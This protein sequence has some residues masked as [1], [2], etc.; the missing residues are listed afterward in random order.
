MLFKTNK[1]TPTPGM[2]VSSKTLLHYTCYLS[3]IRTWWWTDS[4][5]YILPKPTNENICCVL[6][7]VSFFRPLL[8]LSLYWECKRDELLIIMVMVNFIPEPL[9]C[10]GSS[11]QYPLNRWLE[12][13]SEAVWIFWR[14]AESHAPT[15]IW[16]LDHLSCSL[17]T[18]LT[19]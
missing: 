17:V 3:C 10:Q 19:S 7:D 12:W 16:T 13:A 18:G 4:I 15:G 2:P 5:Q 14:R 6:T 8:Q 1:H 11:S 9:Y